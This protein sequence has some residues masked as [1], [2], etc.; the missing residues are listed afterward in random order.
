M[1]TIWLFSIN[2]AIANHLDFVLLFVTLVKLY[3]YFHLP[4]PCG[5]LLWQWYVKNVINSPLFW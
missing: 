3:G 4:F 1:A 5:I 2:L